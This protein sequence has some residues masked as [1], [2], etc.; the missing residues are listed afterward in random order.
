M[1]SVLA[2]RAAE[3]ETIDRLVAGVDAGRAA[4]LSIIGEAGIGKTRLLDELVRRAEARGHLT[5]SGV[6]SE[7]AR[8]VPFW[9]FADALED[10]VRGL[11]PGLLAPMGDETLAAL[12]QVLP[13]LPGVSG[14][15]SAL[16]NERYR[17]HS[18][19][20]SLLERLAVSQPLVLLL[21]DLHW[22]DSGS[23]ELLLTLL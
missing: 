14:T 6:A 12:R 2:G 17:A 13:G 21:D 10:Y 1:T 20:R 22:S 15:V 16:V 8:D 3:L 18:A 5:L 11:D 23:L 9:V 7:L 4:T 19:V